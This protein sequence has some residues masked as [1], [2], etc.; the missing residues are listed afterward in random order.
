MDGPPFPLTGWSILAKKQYPLWCW[1]VSPLLA[2]SPCG[3]GWGGVDSL[4][5]GGVGS[6]LGSLSQGHSLSVRHCVLV[7]SGIALGLWTWKGEGIGRVNVCKWIYTPHI[8]P[9]C[10]GDRAAGLSHPE[11]GGC[12]WR[13]WWSE[14]TCTRPPQGPLSNCPHLSSCWSACQECPLVPLS[15]GPSRASKTL[16]E[17]FPHLHLSF[18]CPGLR[19]T[20]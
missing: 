18:L 5:G 11:Q 10:Q 3:S 20:I 1:S 4:E 15:L 7:L 2:C 14:P 12:S 9:D 16:P 17:G 8:Y 19:H 13:L 6:H